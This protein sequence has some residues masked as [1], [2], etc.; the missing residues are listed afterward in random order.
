MPDIDISREEIK[1]IL[2]SLDVSKATGS[3]DIPGRVLKQHSD[4]FADILYLLFTR[5]YNEGN[6]PRILKLAN[7]VPIF[8]KGDQK[9]PN[10]YRPVSLM[11]II[12]KVL[13]IIM[14]KTLEKYII[15]NKLLDNRQHGFRKGRSTSTNLIKFWEEVSDIVDQGFDVSIIYTDFKKAFDSVPHDLLLLKLERY[16]IKGKNLACF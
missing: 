1:A 2:D 14:K 15:D 4:I 13:E 11:P 10:N 3:D 12:S 9:N 7:V 16:G 8:K 6:I 5:I